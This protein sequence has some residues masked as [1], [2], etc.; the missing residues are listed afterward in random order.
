[1]ITTRRTPVDDYLDLPIFK[2]M[3]KR[4]LKKFLEKRRKKLVLYEVS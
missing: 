2:R 4:D 1:M 3:K